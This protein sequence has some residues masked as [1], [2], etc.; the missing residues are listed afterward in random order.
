MGACVQIQVVRPQHASLLSS[1][2][3]Y[4]S[5]LHARSFHPLS[6]WRC[7]VDNP[8]SIQTWTTLSTKNQELFAE[9]RQFGACVCCVACVFMCSCMFPYACVSVFSELEQAALGGVF[10]C[11]WGA[12]VLSPNKSLVPAIVPGEGFWMRGSNFTHPS[13]SI[14]TSSQAS[15]TTLSDPLGLAKRQ[16]GSAAGVGWDVWGGAPWPLSY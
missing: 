3:P 4:C 1:C 9:G 15:P 16:R 6:C 8:C 2:P 7:P 12:T 11:S 10:C 5:S 14:P 13:F